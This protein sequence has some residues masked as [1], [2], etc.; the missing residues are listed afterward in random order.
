[1]QVLFHLKARLEI[2]NYRYTILA[3]LNEINSSSQPT[4]FSLVNISTISALVKYD[5]SFEFSH[6]LDI[7]FLVR[8]GCRCLNNCNTDSM[9][10][11]IIQFTPGALRSGAPSRKH[12]GMLLSINIGDMKLYKLYKSLI[13]IT[14]G[15]LG[16][17]VSMR[18]FQIIFVSNEK[19]PFFQTIV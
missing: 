12:C 5:F 18:Q 9:F 14:M 1:M 8:M 15:K 17:I 6:I 4:T 10:S 16:I 11:F 2:K 3:S 7:V 13:Y 19:L